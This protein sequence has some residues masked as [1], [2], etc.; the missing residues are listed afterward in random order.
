MSVHPWMA[1]ATVKIA[2]AA[3]VV[4]EAQ[5]MRQLPSSVEKWLATSAIVMAISATAF[6]II[7]GVYQARQ[8]TQAASEKKELEQRIKKYGSA[9]GA[10]ETNAGPNRDQR[11]LNKK[12]K[13]KKA[14]KETPPEDDKS[15]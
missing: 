4:Q 11:R 3:E 1:G 14:P 13:S 7:L 5:E 12:K 2:E 15:K 10:P 6:A 9:F 8:S